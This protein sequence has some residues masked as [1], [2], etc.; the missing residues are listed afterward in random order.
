M[1]ANI[2]LASVDE[3]LHEVTKRFQDRLD[4]IVERSSN[5]LLTD[6]DESDHSEDDI[7]DTEENK[8]TQHVSYK[9]I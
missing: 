9:K 4:Y 7:P 5:W 3:S 6:S 1:R 8:F 2:M